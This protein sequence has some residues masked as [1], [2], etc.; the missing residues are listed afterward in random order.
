MDDADVLMAN[1]CEAAQTLVGEDFP[2]A[3]ECTFRIG[4]PAK[5]YCAPASGEA[6]RAVVLTAKKA[7]L[8]VFVLGGGSN[9]LFKDEGFPGLVVSTKR[10]AHVLASPDGMFRVGAGL[11]NQALTDLTLLHR[12]AGFEWASGLPGSVG[13]G[14]YM[15]AKCYGQS[16]GAIVSKVRVF[17]LESG[18][19]IT[20]GQ[21]ECGFG[22]KDSIFQHRPYVITD[23]QLA[24]EP[25]D[26]G[27]IQKATA[28]NLA[29]RQAK[30][31]F[32]FP[33]AGCA[34]KNDYKV[35]ISSG[36]LIEQAGLKGRTVGGVKVYEQ[37]ANFIVNI[38]TGTA[39]DVRALMD[40]IKAEVKAKQG[41]ELEEEVRVVG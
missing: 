6:L 20:L 4:G 33:S 35:G 32:A 5:Y 14:V 12:M 3:G 16:Y 8:P 21:T 19:W 29:D 18:D 25:G 10:V 13:G 41:V 11:G 34:F 27:E 28:A 37:H 1:L 7:G 24:F 2:L 22:Y 9:V 15:N 40:I 30:G 38:G 26:L 31:Q 36:K 17:D 23:V 39:K